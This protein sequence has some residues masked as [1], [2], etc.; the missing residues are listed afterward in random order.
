MSF[1]NHNDEYH[2]KIFSIF[3]MI[4]A[5]NKARISFHFN[6]TAGNSHILL[7][8]WRDCEYYNKMLP[9]IRSS[10]DTNIYII[11]TY[12][13]Y[14]FDDRAIVFDTEKRWKN[15]EFVFF[16]DTWHAF[17]IL[18]LYRAI[19]INDADKWHKYYWAVD[20]DDMR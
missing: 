17:K 13:K 20:S 2:Y 8:S 19:M 16:I 11:F 15:F 12:E 6:R 18:A 9:F 3:F 1:A 14:L 4:Y 5:I 7:R 10:Q